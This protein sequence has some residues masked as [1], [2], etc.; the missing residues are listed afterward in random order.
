MPART[1]A[2]VGN[3]SRTRAGYSPVGLGAVRLSGFLGERVARNN[4]SSIPLGFASPVVEP[5]YR[6]NRNQ[7]LEPIHL[8]FVQDSDTYK[9]VE[10]ACYAYAASQD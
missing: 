7:P 2:L 4:N 6:L 8:R 3:W 10:G 5:F 1:Q 9:L